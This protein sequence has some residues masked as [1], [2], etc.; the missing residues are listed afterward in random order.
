MRKE[1]LGG[2][3]SEVKSQV[4]RTIRFPIFLATRGIVQMPSASA[5]RS[6]RDNLMAAGQD[7][8]LKPLARWVKNGR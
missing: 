2:N 6:E 7:I 1:Y 3:H 5:R 4:D 8:S